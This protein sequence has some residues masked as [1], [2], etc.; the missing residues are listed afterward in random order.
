MKMRRTMGGEAFLAA[1]AAGA[2][3]ARTLA[4][5]VGAGD[6]GELLL[7]AE[8][9]GVPHPPGY[10]LWTLLARAAASFPFG[11][12]AW[13]VNA[14]SALLAAISV[15]LLYVLARQL[16]AGRLGAAAASAL[17][18]ISVPLWRVAVEAEVY[19]LAAVA[20]LALVL[21]ARRARAARSSGARADALFFFVAGL[22]VL[23][24]Q[25]LVAPTLVL[26]AW[27]LGRDFAWRRV[28]RA[29]GWGLLGL[30]PSLAVAWRATDG[31][32]FLW[33]ERGALQTLADVFT[34]QA[35]GG[36]AQNPWRLDLV[37]DAI[38]GMTRS[39]AAG[40]GVAALL[41][42][43]A[44]LLA[45]PAG[46]P[47]RAIAGRARVS[48]SLR[49]L[50]PVGAAAASVPVAL[51]ALLVF[52]P[53]AEHFAQ[54]EPFLLPVVAVVAL[55]AGL[56][57]GWPARSRAGGAALAVVATAVILTGVAHF[58]RADR[59]GFT[60]PERYGRDLLASAPRGATLVVD[61]D[62]ETFLAA[63]L[64]RY[65]GLRPDLAVVH[66]RSCVFGDSNGLALRPRAEWAAAAREADARRIADPARIV[67]FA[68]VPADLAG[69]GARFASVGLVTRAWA[70]E[71]PVPDVAVWSP[72]AG[73]PRSSALL[74]GD[75]KRY[76]FV[77]RKLAVSYSD[78]AARALVARG[79]FEAALPWCEDAALVGYDMPEAQWNLAVAAAAAGRPE[80]ALDALLAARSLAPRRAESASR[81]ALFLS[82]AGHHADAARWFE[83]AYR[84]EP[85]EALAEDAAR[86]WGLAGDA[87]RA[88]AWSGGL[89]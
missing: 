42:A 13:R 35:Y 33:K 12:L 47:L 15:G 8:T 54:V 49:L 25:T 37:V 45:L 26:G 73:W 78:A 16:G 10:P 34:R 61:G 88:R 30:S 62:N 52:T 41:L 46:A 69:P 27:V 28:A 89:G 5:G 17:F 7:A 86:A 9:L 29:A 51:A 22:A 76:D 58:G 66:R 71:S 84:D 74:S 32:A 77:T 21:T 63:Y 83:R 79:D 1:A 67:V 20:F 31:S 3:Y 57:A 75:P 65:E 56:G 48:R 81:L 38:G 4:P 24:H 59:S 11:E 72:P 18:A 14:L 50:A 44:A 23:A 80:R 36:M 43:A 60:L 70:G 2:L 6:S 82:A 19:S 85:S 39:V 53:D 64:I 87:A 55:A 40:A 68:G